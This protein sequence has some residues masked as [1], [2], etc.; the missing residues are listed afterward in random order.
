[1][2]RVLGWIGV[3]A[4]AGLVPG[5]VVMGGS[6]FAGNPAGQRVVA[7]WLPTWD[8]RAAG[9][10]APALDVGRL[11]EVSP[12]WATVR[13]DG[14]LA[15]TP[16]SGQVRRTLAAGHV[17]VIPVVQNH[18]DM[19]WQ[20]DRIARILKDPASAAA[21]LRALVRAARAEHWNGI[22]VDYEGLPPTVGPQFLAFLGALRTDLHADGRVLAVSV[23]ARAR[24][25]DPGTFAYSY[26]AIGRLVD[27][28]R[29]MA[30]DHAWSGSAAGP[31]APPA[32]VR[33]VVGYAVARAPRDKLMLGVA[34]YGYDWVG[35][36]GAELGA[37]DAV[38]L[39]RRVGAQP[40]WLAAAGASTFSYQAGGRRHTVW[41]EDARS[42]AAK[43]QIAVDAGLRGIAIW[44]LGGE[45]PGVWAS[46]GR[47]E[48]AAG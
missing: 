2:R 17:R 5:S 38:A 16:P 10:L 27:E 14:E 40:V 26:Q 7:A 22:D 37:D 33:A 9:S 47:A 11:S 42:L 29:V 48:G 36:K 34:T 21:H 28:V 4:C 12:T 24:D 32:W 41:F 6:S 8:E 31:I 25:D 18:E 13:P 45:D 1:M 15:L 46:V 19:A 39:A 3:L 23:P 30:Y 35:K 44:R 20:G 43:R